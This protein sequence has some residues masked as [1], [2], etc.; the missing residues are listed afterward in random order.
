MSTSPILQSVSGV[1]RLAET[2]TRQFDTDGNGQLSA[3]EFTSVLTRA[4]SNNSS[5]ASLPKTT[6]AAPQSGDSRLTVVREA[7]NRQSKIQSPMGNRQST[8]NRHSPIGNRI[9][10][11][12]SP[13]DN[14]IGSRQSPIGIRR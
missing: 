10:D 12:Q 5:V 14:A 8:T 7:L 9:A 11:S 13:I 2:L 3:Q 1:H 6:G 4:L